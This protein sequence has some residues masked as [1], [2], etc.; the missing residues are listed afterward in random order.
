MKI[1]I[2]GGSGFLGKNLTNFFIQKKHKVT[3]FDKKKSFLKHKN[4]K[5]IVGD[6]VKFN[7]VNKA[8]K[9]HDFVYNFAGISDIED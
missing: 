9:G 1:I 2:F 8:I 4:L 7:D 6:I 5:N 3:I